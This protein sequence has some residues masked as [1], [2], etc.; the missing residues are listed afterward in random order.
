MLSAEILQ[1]VKIGDFYY[2]LDTSNKTAEVVYTDYDNRSNYLG[3][4]VADIPTSIIYKRNI[5]EVTGIGNHAFS[6]CSSLKEIKFSREIKIGVEAFTNCTSLK[7]ITF[8]HSVI[9]MPY[10]FGNPERQDQQYLQKI[11]FNAPA[12]IKH[13]GVLSD[14]IVFNA[15]PTSLQKDFAQYSTL[16]TPAGQNWNEKFLTWG[17]TLNQKI[18]EVT[19]SS[20]SIKEL[21][22]I[23]KGAE[24]L[25][26]ITFDSSIQNL[27]LTYETFANN[28][29]Y[30]TIIFDCPV[31][32]ERLAFCN[33]INIGDIVFNKQVS[34]KSGAF[35]GDSRFGKN[36]SIKKIT[37]NAP[38]TIENKG[39]VSI[40]IENMVFNAMPESLAK[41]FSSCQNIRVP[42]EEGSIERF[43]SWDINS[44]F[45]IDQTAGLTLDIIVTEPGNIL[46][47]LPIDKLSNIKSLTITGHL[48]ETDAAVLKMCTNLQY[49]NLADSYISESPTSQER[50]Q[51][52][53]KMWADIAELAAVNAA[54]NVETGQSTKREAK[55]QVAEAMRSAAMLQKQ[56]M[57]ECYIP[58]E[59]FM[60]M[61]LTEVVLPKSVKQI[62]ARAFS[63]CKS[64]QKVDLGEALLTIGSEAFANTQLTN[65]S[66]P[67]TLKEI[68]SNAFI[69]VQTLQEI[70]LSQCMMETISSVHGINTNIG[71]KLTNLEKY[72]MPQ[73]VTTCNALLYFVNDIHEEYPKFKDYYI[74]KDVKSIDI[75]LKNVSLHFQTELAPSLGFG[76]LSNCIIYVPKNGNITSYYAAFNGNGNKIIQE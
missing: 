28:P 22:N 37:F 14:T 12:D 47:F 51:A 49:L 8:D 24:G 70:N 6:Y 57:P 33:H 23:L 68:Y 69:N 3:I 43:L 35:S 73:G 13:M 74:G 59:T 56:G 44:D 7:T 60:N 63:G 31:V 42:N 1:G 45:L 5:Y 9:I 41:D 40:D 67:E 34:I 64:L 2:N 36:S 30:E 75:K 19:F 71:R 4:T 58:A 26:K 10:A 66:F 20:S 55:Q 32:I 76:G 53:N 25:K 39:F 17:I 48:Y 15:L 50:R 65:I 54:V 27:S 11:I 72:Y 16:I 29:T 46:K 61:R 18:E 21:S 38:S 62:N 52:E